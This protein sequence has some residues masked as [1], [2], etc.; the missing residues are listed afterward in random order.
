MDSSRH[1][2]AVCNAAVRAIFLLTRVDEPEFLQQILAA[3]IFEKYKK[4]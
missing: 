3:E 4:A 1:A 2:L